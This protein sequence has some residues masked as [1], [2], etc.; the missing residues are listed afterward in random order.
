M[1][2]PTEE[3]LAP[4]PE[5][6]FW[7]V[8]S[9]LEQAQGNVVRAVNTNMVLAYWLIGREIVEEFQRGEERAEYGKQLI[10]ELS[11]RLTE[12]YGKGFSIAN[13]KNFRQFFLAYSQRL[14]KSYPAGSQLPEAHTSYPAGSELAITPIPRPMGAE[15]AQGFSPQ[16]TWSH[17]RAL[18]RVENGAARDFY[19][20]E[21]SECGWS[22]AQRGMP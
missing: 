14:E 21:A 9:I 6:L 22:K 17:Y 18:M 7:R 8:V 5:A 15:S 12:R 20:M 4:R 3:I 11:V 10:E 13:I 19:E 2:K 1:S 16:L